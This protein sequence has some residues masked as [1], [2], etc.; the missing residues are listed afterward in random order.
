MRAQ[1]QR[2]RA[3]LSLLLLLECALVLL[4]TAQNLALFYVG[5]E[6][7]MIPLYV[8]MAAWGGEGRR[9][10]TLTFFI[11]TLVGSLLMLV[12]VAWVGIH[13]QSFQIDVLSGR[14]LD[15]TW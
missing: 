7:M 4:F 10:A 15:S 9:R 1:R 3:Y 14:R 6:A 5:W 11:Y 13:G 12:A 8:L 2:P